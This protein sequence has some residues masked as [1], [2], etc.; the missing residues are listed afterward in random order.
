VGTSLPFGCRAFFLLNGRKNTTKTQNGGAKAKRHGSTGFYWFQHRVLAGSM[1]I[2]T[3]QL[4]VPIIRPI[5][6]F[7][8]LS[9]AGT[10]VVQLF[11]LVL[12]GYKG[13]LI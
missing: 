6:K 4:H 5:K 9:D 11:F 10:G 13:A 1:K 12:G 2:E 3:R 8:A 7:T